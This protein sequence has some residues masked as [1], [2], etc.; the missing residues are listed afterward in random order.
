MPD[1]EVLGDGTAAARSGEE[2]ALDLLQRTLGAEK[3][4]EVAP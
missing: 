3:I 2:Q 4:G 1:D